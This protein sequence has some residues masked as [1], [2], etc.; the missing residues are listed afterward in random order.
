MLDH[1][2]LGVDN[3]IFIIVFITELLFNYCKFYFISKKGFLMEIYRLCQYIINMLSF[4]I[5]CYID[6]CS[7]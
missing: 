1:V 4:S 2:Q 6:L 7:I 5:L 3:S